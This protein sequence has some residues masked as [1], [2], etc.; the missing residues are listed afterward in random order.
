MNCPK[1]G[2]DSMIIMDIR[3]CGGCVKT[4]DE[5]TCE[6]LREDSS[7]SEVHLLPPTSVQQPARD[8]LVV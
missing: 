4:F 2:H 3:Y 1:C 8:P 5:C 6:P 7:K